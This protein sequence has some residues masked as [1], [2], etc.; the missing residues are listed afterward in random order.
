[1]IIESIDL[2]IQQL[3]KLF[4]VIGFIFMTIGQKSM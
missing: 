4:R 2:N 3:L 1:M